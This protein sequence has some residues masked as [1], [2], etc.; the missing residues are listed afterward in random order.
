MKAYN[1]LERNVARILD[2]FPQLKQIAKTTYQRFNYWYFGDRNFKLYLHPQVRLLT[3][4]QWTGTE[5]ESGELFFGYYDKSPWSQ[6]MM[7]TV[8]HRLKGNSQIEIVVYDKHKQSSQI[9]G[10]SSTWSLQ[11]GSMTQWLPASKDRK[12]IFNDLV[13]GK[14]AARIV[15]LDGEEERIVLLPIQTIHPNG[16][17][18][19]TLNYKRLARLRPEYGYSVPASNF[20]SEC[21]LSQDGIWLINLVSGQSKLIIDLDTLAAYQPRAEMSNA[22]RK[23]N[24]ILYSPQG[25]RFVFMHRWIGSQ[26]KFSRLYVANSDG[27]NLKLLFDERMVSHYSWRDEEYLLVWART[28]QAGDRYYLIHAVTGQWQIIG[29]G[30]LDIYGDG[31]PSFSPNRRWIITDTYPDRAR[32]Q[33]LLLYEVETE[34]LIEI[35]RFLEPLQFNS[36]QRCD[37]H[38]RWSPDGQAI[39]IDSTHEGKRMTYI[40]DVSSIVN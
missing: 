7:R 10:T 16:R 31:H 18:A 25:T 4:S 12:I 11:Q 21:P 39:S 27:S 32:Q 3:P 22:D 8:F 34:K 2:N 13:E 40:L 35:G 24:H 29:K 23:I 15:S 36:A 9:V 5:T 28:K 6:A 1:L 19:L 38:P 14:L 20:S 26:G 17:E 37:L 33:H 30:I